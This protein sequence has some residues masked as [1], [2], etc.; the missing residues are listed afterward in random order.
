[1][2]SSDRPAI[3]TIGHSNH[4]IDR[5]LDLL[6]MHAVTLVADV[7]SVPYSRRHPDYNREALRSALAERGIMYEFLGD[8]LGARPNDRSCYA[9]GRVQYRRLAQTTLF[10]SGL[11]RVLNAAKR[12]QVA[13]L[14]AEREP[15]AC[16]RTILVARELV[17]LGAEVAHIYADGHSEP[18]G[19]AMERLL[20][21]LG[22]R[23]FDLFGGSSDRYEKAY[24][25]QEARIA[26]SLSTA[27]SPDDEREE[28]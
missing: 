1:M 2:I 9:N 22:L 5:F 28:P 6:S 12:Q 13:L 14:C 24:A 18:H 3:L 8:A 27:A 10:R 15:L 4:P 26:Y 11:D 21:E 7:R 20:D 19:V 25:E 16:H 23:Q 17:D